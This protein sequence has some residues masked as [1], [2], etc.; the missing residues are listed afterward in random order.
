MIATKGVLFGSLHAHGLL[1]NTAIISDRAENDIR[2]HVVKRNVS[3]T[4][5]SEPGRDARDAFL[6][7]MKTCRKLGISAIASTPKAHLLSPP[8]PKLILA[9]KS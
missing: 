1:Q 6:G 7:L 9:D 3:G 5:R 8:R 2:C 4:T